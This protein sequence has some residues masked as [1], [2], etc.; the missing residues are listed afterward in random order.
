MPKGVNPK[1]QIPN[2]KFQAQEHGWELLGCGSWDL[3]MRRFDMD[4]DVDNFREP[5]HQTVFD[6]M[7]ERMGFP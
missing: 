1:S 3:L 7:R 2:P 4:D 6:D 5:F